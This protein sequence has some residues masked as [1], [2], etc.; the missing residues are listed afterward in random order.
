[1]AQEHWSYAS[2]SRTQVCNFLKG[3][4]LHLDTHSGK[5]LDSIQ[6]IFKRETSASF[7][8]LPSPSCLLSYQFC[9]FSFCQKC[10]TLLIF[11]EDEFV[12]KEEESGDSDTTEMSEADLEV[13]YNLHTSVAD[14][15]KFWVEIA[16]AGSGSFSHPRI[17]IRI[18]IHTKMSWI[19]NTAFHCFKPWALKQ[20][21][22]PYLHRTFGE[23]S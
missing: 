19:R 6:A 13:L 8:H 16:G 22:V 17:Q 12:V 9:V 3:L 15:W 4:N 14:Q 7:V 18:R 5:V 21:K 23:F 1:M 11:S 10:R 2:G 20:L